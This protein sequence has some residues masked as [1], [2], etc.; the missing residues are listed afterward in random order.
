MAPIGW[1]RGECDKAEQGRARK[2]GRT[3]HPRR[4]DYHADQGRDQNW[5]QHLNGQ[6]I[7]PDGK[8]DEPEYICDSGEDEYKP[9][10]QVERRMPAPD[11]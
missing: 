1:T 11:C 9:R 7:P 6:Q 8:E 2:H 10:R 3:P 4:R 5:R